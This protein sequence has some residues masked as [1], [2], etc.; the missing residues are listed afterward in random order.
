MKN[1][2][3]IFLTMAAWSVFHSWLAALR[4]KERVRKLFGKTA[5]RFYRLGFVLAAVLTLAP[6]LLLIGVLPSRVLWRIRPPWLYLTVTLQVLAVLG[7]IAGVLH[8]DVMAFIGLR[9]LLSNE[10]ERQEKLVI[11][12]FYKW[13]R[14]PLY[15]LGLIF[16]WLIPLVT[17]LIL[18]FNIAA[19]L[20][21][22]LGT[23]P[24][25]QKLVKT[26]GQA[27]VTYQKKVPRLIPGTKGRQE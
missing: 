27:Y 15:F 5:D 2:L 4:T 6:I 25:E 19:S 23:L 9:Q 13:V 8:T 14:H 22:I 12:G 11:K 3:L 20:Y 21:L 17:D 26:F 16:I 7:L 10:L 1:A 24:E 18:A